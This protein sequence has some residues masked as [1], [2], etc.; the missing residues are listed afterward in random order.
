MTHEELKRFIGK[1]V[2]VTHRGLI[3]TGKYVGEPEKFKWRDGLV[4]LPLEKTARQ[5]NA[6]KI[7]PFK[8]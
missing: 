1:K 7:Q 5:F 4:Q 3:L 8:P 6:D 2:L